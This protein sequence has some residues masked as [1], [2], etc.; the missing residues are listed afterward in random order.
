MPPVEQVKA[1]RAGVG[2]R[3]W[4]RERLVPVSPCSLRKA[5]PAKFFSSILR[6]VSFTPGKCLMSPATTAISPSA[7]HY[8]TT[9]KP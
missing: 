9:A 4:D 7:A 6:A 1:K 5:V 3:A 8:F 2:L